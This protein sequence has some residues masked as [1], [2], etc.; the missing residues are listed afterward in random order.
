MTCLKVSFQTELDSIL[1]C[2][3]VGAV[4]EDLLGILRIL[5][6]K[7]YFG[8]EEYNV[9]LKSLGFSSYEGGD[10]PYPVPTSKS[11]KISKLKGKAVSQW[12]H[13]RNWPL[14][15]KKLVKHS[16]EDDVI[17]LGLKLHELVERLTAIEFF[18]YEVDLLREKLV[19][20]LTLRKSIR[21][22]FPSLMT[23]AKPKHHFLRW[24]Y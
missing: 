8:I 21:E 12:V 6:F 16:D 14:V 7:G 18:P 10:A 23:N 24:I 22:E 15:M 9:C 2:F 4:P 13:A 17:E 19:Q 20:Y 3:I 1:L 5:E 11:R